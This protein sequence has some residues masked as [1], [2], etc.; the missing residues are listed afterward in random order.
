MRTWGD[1]FIGNR[2]KL[3]PVFPREVT[4][5]VELNPVS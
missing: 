3:L 2:K 1:A 5:H 4:R